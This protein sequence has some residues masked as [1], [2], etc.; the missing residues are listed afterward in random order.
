MNEPMINLP[1]VLERYKADLTTLCQQ[2]GVVR[3]YAFGSVVTDRF[4]PEK[5]DLDLL[6]ELEGM[7]PL[8]RGEKLIGLWDAL[9][10]LLGRR[11]DLLTDQP[12]KNTYLR[13]NVHSTK[14]LIYDR[15]SRKVLS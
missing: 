9:E 3:L 10:D 4:D 6:V 7:P 1:K 12:I 11:V 15:K 13:P 2:F 8:V 5:S 14:Q